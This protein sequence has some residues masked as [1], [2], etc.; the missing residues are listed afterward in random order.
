MKDN[1]KKD[2]RSERRD[3]AENRRRI[4]EAASGLFGQHGVTQVS[5]NQI[6]QEARI[7]P[8]T[9]YRRYSSKGEICLDLIKDQIDGLFKDIEAYL[10]EN[11]A[12]PPD[13]KLKGVLNLFIQFR[14]N[15]N[16]LLK[17][18]E[19]SAG[20]VKSKPFIHDPLYLRLHEIYVRLF[21]EQSVK[22]DSAASSVFKADMLL[23]L[24]KG[25]SYQLQ[26]EVRGYS[27]EQI[28]EQI[29][30]VFCGK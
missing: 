12:T 2:G 7:G 17:G 20:S 24:F 27:P 15:K 30:A 4:L 14:E 11:L 25:D 16:Q 23:S 22:A 13:D 9:L 21:E 8:G 6:A 19:D 10:Q 18:V 5:M 3:A 29:C 26:R 28:V 1:I